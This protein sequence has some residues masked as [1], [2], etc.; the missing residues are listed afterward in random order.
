M[1][2]K[3]F[4]WTIRVYYEDTDTCGIVYYANYLKF[5]ERARTEWLRSV[6]FEQQKMAD[7]L[8]LRFVIARVECEFKLP[9]RLDDVIEV[10]VCVARLGSASMVFNQCAQRNGAVLATARVRVGCIE[11]NSFIPAPLPA[12]LRAAVE[13]LPELNT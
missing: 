10:D 6:G 8:G 4:I 13:R 5:F 2:D 12:Q 1:L 3:P 7:E 9:A 11:A